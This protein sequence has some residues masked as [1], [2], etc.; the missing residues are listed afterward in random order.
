MKALNDINKEV[1]ELVERAYNA[2]FQDG[3]ARAKEQVL[4]AISGDTAA[5][6]EATNQ[7]DS[8]ADAVG[9]LEENDTPKRQRAP[10]GLPRALT[11][12][13][14][15]ANPNGVTP[16]QIVDAAETDFERMIAVSSVRSELRKGEAA[17]RYMEVDGLWHLV[18]SD[19]AEDNSLQ[20]TPSASNSSHERKQDASAVTSNV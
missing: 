17:E 7:Q 19:E 8:P 1:S 16:Q 18:D 5:I 11:T 2:G 9:I 14:L 15:G 13:V 3:L 12:R 10:R 20:G 6:T 4:A